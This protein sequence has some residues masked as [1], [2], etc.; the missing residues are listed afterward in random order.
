MRS[1]SLF[2]ISVFSAV[3]FLPLFA[4]EVLKVDPRQSMA[5]ISHDPSRNWKLK[6]YACVVRGDDELAC[7]YVIKVGP[8]GAVIKFDYRAH[9]RVQR[10]D[11]VELSTN[12]SGKPPPDIAE[13]EEKSKTNAGV[14]VAKPEV[15]P[16]PPPEVPAETL[17][18]EAEVSKKKTSKKAEKEAKEEDGPVDL[19]KVEAPPTPTAT[20]TAK[21]ETSKPIEDNN[22]V[23]S[24][25]APSKFKPHF[26]VLFDWLLTYR[27][28]ITPPLTFDTYH[29]I[30]FIDFLPSHNIYFSVEVNPNPRFYELDYVIF[31]KFTLRMGRIFIPFDDLGPHSFFGGRANVQK[32]VPVGG[33]S[34][35]P[36]IWTDLGVA[37][38]YRW[39]DERDTKSD[40]QFYVVNGF[41]DQQAVDPL[42]RS[43]SYP[44]FG[45]IGT[46]DNNNAKAV[47][48]RF[49]MDLFK[50]VFSFGTS[51]YYDVYT[52]QSIAS[53]ALWMLGVDAQLRLSDT[54]EFRTGYVYMNVELPYS[55]GYFY[56]GGYYAELGQT[57]GI[58]KVLLRG[59]QVQNDSRV[60]DVTDMTIV[61]GAILYKPGPVQLSLEYSRDLNPIPIK[62]NYDY[63]AFRV[64]MEF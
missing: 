1:R 45:S 16:P 10:G 62:I 23:N 59:G 56:R 15:E 41:G 43:P 13:G 17:K 42:G 20:V 37:I 28:G 54:T 8:K 9:H 35:L 34:F 44:N 31:P 19:D 52:S 49:S 12:L 61:G 48:G 39:L 27:P 38:K 24:F 57:F 14:S 7:G 36:D 2:I 51:A 63:A 26:R 32:L 4:A 25:H 11:L 55:L 22:V 21:D 29:N 18:K 30:L 58:W 5:A 47:G 50:N 53:A 60:T 3:T 6:D 40:L 33:T 46:S 64:V